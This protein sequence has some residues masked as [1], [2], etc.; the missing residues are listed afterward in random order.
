VIRSLHAKKITNRC[1][2][3]TSSYPGGRRT[4][5]VC[6]GINFGRAQPTARKEPEAVDKAANKKAASLDDLMGK[7]L[8]EAVR[9]LQRRSAL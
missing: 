7:P 8:G 3:G 1:A 4:G 9:E 6:R 2:G 5:T